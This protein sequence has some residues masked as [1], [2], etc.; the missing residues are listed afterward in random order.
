MEV[1]D[2]KK[3]Y[4][5]KLTGNKTFAVLAGNDNAVFCPFCYSP[6]NESDDKCTNCGKNIPQV[7]YYH[8]EDDTWIASGNE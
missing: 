3:G 1:V 2:T 4:N 6:L 8:G 5:F 7:I